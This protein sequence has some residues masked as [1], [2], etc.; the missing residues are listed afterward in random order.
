M[1]LLLEVS[2][3]PLGS[4]ILGQEKSAIDH[5]AKIASISASCEP[6]RTS[7]AQPVLSA[8]KIIQTG[9]DIEREK[10]NCECNKIKKSSTEFADVE[11][12]LADRLNLAD[13]SVLPRAPGSDL[14]VLNN[15]KRV[16]VQLPARQ[17][18][19]LRGKGTDITVL[20][21]FVLVEAS[22]DN[23]SGSDAGVSTLEAGSRYYS[24][25]CNDTDVY[26]PEG[27][28]TWSDIYISCAPPDAKVTSIDVHYEIVHPCRSDLEVDLTDENLDCEV[29]LWSEEGGCVPNIGETLTGI[30]VC[31]GE[32]V[33]QIWSL[34]AADWWT[35]DTGY[36]NYW[37]IKIYYD[38]SYYIQ[39][40][41]YPDNTIEIPFCFCIGGNP[42]TVNFSISSDCGTL[43]PCY[44]DPCFFEPGYWWVSTKYTPCE[45]ECSYI[46]ITAD[47]KFGQ[48]QK[49][50]VHLDDRYHIG[51]GSSDDEP[52]GHELGCSTCTIDPDNPTKCEP[53]EA[54]VMVTVIPPEAGTV[55]PPQGYSEYTLN[56]LYEFWSTYK[57]HCDYSGR[58][59]VRFLID[60]PS[61]LEDS[62]IVYSFDQNT[63]TLAPFPSWRTVCDSFCTEGF[64]FN[65]RQIYKMSLKASNIYN[66]SLDEWDEAGARCDAGYSVLSIFDSSGNPIWESFGLFRPA[67]TI[68]TIYEDWSPPS[69]G[70]YYLHVFGYDFLGYPTPMSYCLAYSAGDCFPDT[71]T[72]YNDW[73]EM[74]KPNC[75]CGIYGNPPCPYQC[76][77]DADGA[78]EGVF[79]YRAY[80]KDLALIV[81]NWKKKI[82]DPTLNPCADIDHKAEGIFKYRVYGKDL[83]IIVTNWKKIDAALPGNCPRPE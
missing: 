81:E 21:K 61:P 69:D 72:T 6:S 75:W 2:P 17:V 7:I 73:V 74:S 57:P 31:N 48:S 65:W 66:F 9:K 20:R 34:W 16:R 47:P 50:S 30:T 27:D 5:R 15:P 23:A 54:R 13:I 1:A 64:N 29:D 49:K 11:I 38:D 12:L 60:N 80:G 82:D 10:A 3:W 76:D 71:Y 45:N 43:D 24:E 18:R 32:L 14:E 59:R 19:A 39:A 4:S 8:K 53:N 22:K 78:T 63:E 52:Y 79:K 56:E 70:Y 62:I 68:G 28:W 40:D 77:G 25:S 46:E 26:I 42:G 41:A 33:N 35:G 55:D 51:C 83:G 44:A 67:S 37:W 36:I 58:V